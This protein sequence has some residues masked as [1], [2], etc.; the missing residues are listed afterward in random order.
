MLAGEGSWRNYCGRTADDL[1]RGRNLAEREQAL[2]VRGT[3]CRGQR[4][5]PTLLGRCE[6]KLARRESRGRDEVADVVSVDPFMGGHRHQHQLGH[7]VNR[8][9]GRDHLLAKLGAQDGQLDVFDLHRLCL[10]REALWESLFHRGRRLVHGRFATRFLQSGD[11]LEAADGQA[12]IEFG[13]ER[14]QEVG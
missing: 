10:F 6:G 13:Q 1:V 2:A 4:G 5:T 9:V 7:L 11:V 8:P 14:F 3:H 12:Q